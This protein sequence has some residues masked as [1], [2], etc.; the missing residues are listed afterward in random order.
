M[1]NASWAEELDRDITKWENGGPGG[2]RTP[3]HLVRSQVLY[4][5]E[6][7]ARRRWFLQ[8]NANLVESYS[9]DQAWLEVS[10]SP[11][12]DSLFPASSS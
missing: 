8:Q 10:G 12:A 5:A 2:T 4:P 9:I 11:A 1:G 3:D 7:Q 6:L